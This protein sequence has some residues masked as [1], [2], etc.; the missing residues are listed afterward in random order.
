MKKTTAAIFFLLTFFF[1]TFGQDKKPDTAK[2]KSFDEITRDLRKIEG[3]IP[4]YYDDENGKMYL[5]ISRFKREFLYQISLPTGVGSNPIGL[6]RG[7]LGDTKVVYFE[8][9]GNKILLI[10]PNYGYRALSENPAER[11]AVE[12]SFAKSVIW[13]FK[14]EAVEGEKHLVDATSFLIRDA[15]G[16]SNRLNQLK[17]GNYSFEESRS[18]FYL[19]MTKGF[20][21]NTEVEATITLVSKGETGRLIGQTAPTP[22]TVTVRQRHSFVELPD[23]DYRPREFDPRVGVIPISFYDYAAGI[24]ENL[25]KRWI[26]RHRLRKKDPSAARSEAVEPIIYYVDNGAPKDIQDALIEGASWW[27]QAFEA[28]GFINAFQVRVLPPDVDPMDARYNVINWV[29][30]STRGWAY[31]SSITDPRTGEIIKGDVTL[32]SQRARQD[33]LIGSGLAPQYADSSGAMCDFALMPDV[34]YLLNADSKTVAGQMALSRIRQLSAHEVG[35]T[36]GFAHNF[37]A[38]T[39]GRAS[40]MDYPAPVINVKNG[41]LD[42]SDAYAVGIGAYDKFAVKFAYSDFPSGEDEKSELEKIV[43]QGVNDG[44]LFITD[45]DTRPANAAHPLA[46]LW[47]NGPDPI[48]NLRHELEV[49]RIGLRQFGPENLEKGE[50]FSELEKKLLPLYLHHRY[51]LTAAVKSVGGVYYTYAVRGDDGANPSRVFEIVPAERQREALR[52]VLETLKFE[53]LAVPENILKLIPPRAYGFNSQRTEL[54]DKRTAPIFDPIGAAEISAG[55]TIGGLLE[56]NRAARSISFHALDNKQPG[57]SEVVESLISATWKV[58]D[59]TDQYHRAILRAIQ[60]L[61]VNML[62]DLADNP[63][64]QAQVREIAT[65]ALRNLSNQLKVRMANGKNPEEVHYKM[66]IEEIERFLAR[67]APPRRP[68]EKLSEPPGDP[69]GG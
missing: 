34:D 60:S 14:L 21:K 13:G 52:T 22:E 31:G 29:H 30:R 43:R 20:P 23:D 35:H 33:F 39:Y 63:E 65:A 62:M 4:L 42:F 57:F 10:Q 12:E 49:R 38:S 50:P 17:Q 53:E 5:E 54:F 26:I 9:A 41:K 28:A 47:D 66:V 19:P 6:D 58:N 67:P 37:A 15:H 32:D 27:N 24:E 59:P 55:M 64:A 18:A 68:D 61:T 3:F 48:A 56:P 1:L 45:A 2:K 40:V 16:V 69:I 7:Q 11:R 44:M 8:K 36:L 51:Q 46:N 25:E